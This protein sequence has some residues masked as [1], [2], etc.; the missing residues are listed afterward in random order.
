MFAE[1]G[2][3][4]P[5]ERSGTMRFFC[6]QV[7]GII[8]EDAVKALF[9]AKKQKGSKRSSLGLRLMG[10]VWVASFLVWSTPAWLYPVAASPS[11][12]SF[13]P[14]SIVKRLMNN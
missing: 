11:G 3:G 7:Y 4:L 9:S 6:T 8:I 10:Y 5:L 2:G 1:L 14:F 13:L 12:E